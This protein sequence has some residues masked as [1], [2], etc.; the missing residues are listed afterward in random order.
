MP[1]GGGY[2]ISFQPGSDAGINSLGLASYPDG[3]AWVVRFS[4]DGQGARDELAAY[5]VCVAAAGA[6]N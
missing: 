3:S 2:S 5:A 4:P 1:V 6:P